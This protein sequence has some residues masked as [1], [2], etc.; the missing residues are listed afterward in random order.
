[1]VGQMGSQR[2]ADLLQECSIHAFMRRLIGWAVLIGKLSDVGCAEGRFKHEE[3]WNT[4]F[5][6]RPLVGVDPSASVV[7]DVGRARVHLDEGQGADL[8]VITPH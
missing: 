5:V 1:M 2:G 8:H 4:D 3:F 7:A 6:A